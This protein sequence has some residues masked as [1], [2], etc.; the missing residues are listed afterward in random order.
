MK[1]IYYILTIFFLAT[2]CSNTRY[3]QE[4]ELLYIGGTVK[5]NNDSISKKERK[6]LATQ[7]N[8]LIR[9]K[10]NSS[11]L[12][13]KPKL[14]IY[15]WAGKVTTEKGFWHWLKFKV[16][17]P[18]VLFSTVDL[19]YNKAVLQNFAENNGYFSVNATQLTCLQML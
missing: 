19:D 3:L 10:P 14:T 5:I 13:L 18:P 17:E 6:I 9:P 2:A 12:G 8:N 15:N 4:G 7:L 1:N 16:G 11:I